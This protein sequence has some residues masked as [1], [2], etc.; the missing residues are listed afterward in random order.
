MIFLLTYILYVYV[1]VIIKKIKRIGLNKQPTKKKE[2]MKTW[3]AHIFF[4]LFYRRQQLFFLF[5]N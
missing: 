2:K 3:N 1:A 4:L 5:K